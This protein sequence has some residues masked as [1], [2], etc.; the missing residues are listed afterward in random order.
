[1]KRIEPGVPAIK[2][3]SWMA[4]AFLYWFVAS[5]TPARTEAA[6]PEISAAYCK[7]VGTDDH[8]HHVPPA[9]VPAFQRAFGLHAPPQYVERS[10][11]VRCAHGVLLGCGTGANLPCGPADTRRDIPGADTWCRE[12]ADPEIIPAYVTGHAS[13]YAWHCQG[14]HAVP[15]RRIA[16]LDDRGFVARYWKPLG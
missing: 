10:G 12:N 3:M 9:L 8:L 14:G 15:V 13:I 4:M 16:E 5:L 11:F 2:A 7:Q 1:M 6:G